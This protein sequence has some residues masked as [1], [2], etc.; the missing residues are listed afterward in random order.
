MKKQ[1]FVSGILAACFLLPTMG[2]FG[3]QTIRVIETVDFPAG[4]IG[5]LPQKINNNGE[6]AGVIDAST[7]ERRGFVRFHNGNYSK[8]LVDPSD[9]G[10][11]T[12]LRGINNARL[13]NGAFI[14]AD[15]L[16]HGFFA[17]RDGYTTSDVPGANNTILLS[18]NDAGDFCGGYTTLSNSNYTAFIN[19]GGTITTIVVP[20]AATS[21]AYDINN[22]N[23]AVGQ[24]TDASGAAHAFFRDAAGNIT[25]PADPAGATAAVL[26]GL[27]DRGYLVGRYTDTA[28]VERGYVQLPSGTVLTLD[29]PDATLTSLNGINSRNMMCGRFVDLNGVAHG[30]IA[31]ITSQAAE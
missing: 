26:F 8:P 9:A 13:V 21:F 15:G 18:L 29:L 28:G 6:V 16:F 23:E 11:F 2:A 7:G 27:N 10:G 19:V 25:A 20:G 3:Q 1:Y 5:T 4:G 30:I 17:T 31:R 12:D 24:Y 22:N 14:G